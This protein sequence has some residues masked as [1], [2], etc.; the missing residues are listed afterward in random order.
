M[1]CCGRT[2]TVGLRSQYDDG[3][4]FYMAAV[5][6]LFALGSLLG[7]FLPFPAFALTAIICSIAYSFYDFDGTVIRCISDLVVAVL[8]LQLGYFFSVIAT[9]LH[10]R[11]QFHRRSDQ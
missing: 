11:L 4:W 8:A 5:I 9:I 3:L 7:M 6:G 2:V 10:R 1:S